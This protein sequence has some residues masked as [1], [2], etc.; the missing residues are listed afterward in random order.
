MAIVMVTRE[1]QFGGKQIW[2]SVNE[3]LCSLLSVQ[4]R[5]GYRSFVVIWDAH[6]VREDMTNQKSTVSR[7]IT[8]HSYVFACKNN[9]TD[10]FYKTDSAFL[11]DSFIALSFLSYTGSPVQIQCV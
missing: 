6:H 8:V 4:Y 11:R 5:A 3:A 7:D 9:Q 10:N 2:C 1:Y